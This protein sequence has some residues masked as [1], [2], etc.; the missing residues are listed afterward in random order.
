MVWDLSKNSARLTLFSCLLHTK[1]KQSPNVRVCG[2]IMP[3]C[4][5]VRFKFKNIF[6][7]AIFTSRS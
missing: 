6:L 4:P 2:E 7:F 1:E 5:N 3:R